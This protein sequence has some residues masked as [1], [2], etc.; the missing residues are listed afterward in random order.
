MKKKI[1]QKDVLFLIFIVIFETIFIKSL[2]YKVLPTRYFNDGTSILN[3]MNSL[4]VLDRSYQFVAEIFNSIN[5][6]H[7]ETLQQWSIFLSI[8][9]TPIVI[10]FIEKNKKYKFSQ[11]IFLIASVALLNLY[12]FN[13]SKDIIQFIYFLVIYLILIS[14]YKNLTKLILCCIVLLHEA[15]NFRIY[16]AIMAMVMVTIYFVY[17]LFIKNRKLNAKNITRIISLFLI[18]FFIEIFLVNVVSSSNYQAIM[19]ARYDVNI[20]REFDSNA[21]TIIEEPLGQNT[22]YFKF[23]INYVINLVR[24]NFPIELL[25]RGITYIPFIIYQLYILLQLIRGLKKISDN[26]ILL[27]DIIISFIMISTIFEPDFGSFIRHESV[28]ILLFQR[29]TFLN[30]EGNKTKEEMK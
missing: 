4:I 25:F 7:F 23:I 24:I 22:N 1:I 21:R 3:S 5:F 14:K 13:L 6:F 20:Q 10:F 19:N 11:I 17:N 18:A 12:V 8:I 29:L 30:Y 16:Y 28:L 9:F 2:Q 26:N 15:L 27:L